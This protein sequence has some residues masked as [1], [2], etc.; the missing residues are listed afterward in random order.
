MSD[1]GRPPSSHSSAFS[2]HHRLSADTAP[3]PRRLSG[4]SSASS[5]RSVPHPEHQQPPAGRQTGL[6]NFNVSGYYVPGNLGDLDAVTE[7]LGSLGATREYTLECFE[8]G[9]DAVPKPRLLSRAEILREIRGIDGTHAMYIARKKSQGLLF[10]SNVSAG[11]GLVAPSAAASFAAGREAS[12]AAAAFS[13]KQVKRYLRSSVQSRDIRQIDPAFSQKPALWVRHNAVVISM[14]HIRAIITHCK[15]YI[16]DTEHPRVADSI[17]VVQRVIE[18][19]GKGRDAFEGEVPFEFRALEGLFMNLCSNL[20]SDFE[21]IEPEVKQRLESK[22]TS[23]D[24]LDEFRFFQQ[25]TSQ[26]SARVRKL[27]AVFQ[28]VLDDD[29]DMSNMYLTELLNATRDRTGSRDA[30][31]HNEVEYLLESYLQVI[32]DLANKAE[33]MAESISDSQNLLEIHL[34]TQQNRLL[35]VE[36]VITVVTTALAFAGLVTAIFG[37][38]FPLPVAVQV[39]PSSYYYFLGALVLTAVLSVSILGGM[40]RY[41]RRHGIYGGLY[42]TGKKKKKRGGAAKS[43]EG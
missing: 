33:L 20:S 19:G 39:L 21:A 7:G 43:G 13:K 28:S 15:L 11:M 12:A 32:D 14:E 41:L 6:G 37:M 38:N 29:D 26:F 10:G 35:L 17:A 40:M 25:K 3:L 8:I 16:F 23:S 2:R 22:Q 27:Q 24:I 4:L 9:E 5:R 31:D 36:L 34:N 42:G 1:T 18:A 30:S